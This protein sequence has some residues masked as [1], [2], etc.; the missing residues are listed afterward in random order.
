[1][2]IWK[3]SLKYPHIKSF[4]YLIIEI[5]LGVGDVYN[6]YLDMNPKDNSGREIS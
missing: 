4:I 2:D 1:M 5:Y 6:G 3:W